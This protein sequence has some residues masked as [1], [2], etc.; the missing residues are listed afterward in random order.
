MFVLLQICPQAIGPDD[1]HDPIDV[2]GVDISRERLEQYLTTYRERHR[3]ACTELEERLSGCGD[4]WESAHD[5]V[6][7]EIADKHRIGGTLV[8]EPD[9]IF[10]ILE[11]AE[12]EGWPAIT[13]IGRAPRS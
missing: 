11:V 8:P 2:I 10:E 12:S 7:D 6:H 1:L 13:P 3:V 5:H 4:D 9:A